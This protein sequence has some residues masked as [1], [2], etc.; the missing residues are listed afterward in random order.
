M[1]LGSCHMGGKVVKGLQLIFEGSYEGNAS[2][3]SCFAQKTSQQAEIL[4]NGGER[5]PGWACA[6]S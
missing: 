5:F 4:S 1:L 2:T 3:Y 6:C